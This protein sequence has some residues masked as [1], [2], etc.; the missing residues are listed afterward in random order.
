MTAE[1]I[2]VGD[3][4]LGPL[5]GNVRVSGTTFSINRLQ[6]GYRGGSVTGQ[7]QAELKR[8]ASLLAFRGNA[9]GIHTAKGGKDVLDANLALR[10]A[11][12]SLALDGTVQLVRL[13]RAHLYELLDVLDPYHEDP[14]MN[15]VRAALAVGYPRFARLQAAE[16]L[17]DFEI[18][19]G[20]LAGAVSIDPI[21]AIPI[22]PLTWR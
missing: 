3:Q 1:R 21:R 15:K 20:G 19:L 18:A 5:A 12:E 6:V 14:P 2:V 16:G 4:R 7:L 13:S 8:G 17:M 11:P 22:A 10:F 9:T